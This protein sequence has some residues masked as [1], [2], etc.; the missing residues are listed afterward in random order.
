[1]NFQFEI[2]L[3]SHDIYLMEV[4]SLISGG[5][6]GGGGGFRGRGGKF[7]RFFF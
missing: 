4:I 2:F 3:Q 5:G 7:S 1:M 6:G